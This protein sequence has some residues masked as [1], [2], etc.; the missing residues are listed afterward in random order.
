MPFLK[1]LY[2]EVSR[3]FEYAAKTGSSETSETSRENI[4]GQI[5]SSN[6]TVVANEFQTISAHN[7]EAFLSG[8]GVPQNAVA[9]FQMLKYVQVGQKQQKAFFLNQSQASLERIWVGVRKLNSETMRI[10]LNWVGLLLSRNVLPSLS[11][12]QKLESTT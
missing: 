6:S 1:K 12:P 8:K 11:P 5:T 4:G 3:P 10:G 9:D 7:F 2:K